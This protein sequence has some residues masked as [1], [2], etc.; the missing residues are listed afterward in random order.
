M[1]PAFLLRALIL[2]LVG[3]LAAAAASAQKGVV[4]EGL[5]SLGSESQLPNPYR[6]DA[7][8]IRLGAAAYELHCATCHGENATR[9]VAEGPDLRRLNSFCSL[10]S[11]APLRQHCL[12]DVDTYFLHS[13]REGKL[14]AGQMHMP[15]WKDILPQELI[16]AIRSFTE[17]RPVP[18]PRTLPDLPPGGA[19]VPTAAG[20][21]NP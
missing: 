19:F 17:T 18:P 9:P 20:R 16:W 15:A 8:A 14:R 3:G 10:L 1:T 12:R 4:P 5:R 11:E 21:S 2:A 6:G 13:V 7:V